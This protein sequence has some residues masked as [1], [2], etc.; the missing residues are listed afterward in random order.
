MLEKREILEDIRRKDFEGFKRSQSYYSRAG[1][2]VY[3]MTY[4]VNFQREV[5]ALAKKKGA[6]VKVWDVGCGQGRFLRELKQASGEKI[7]TVGTTATRPPVA[8]GID[9]L[10]IDSMAAPR[11]KSRFEKEKG[12]DLIVSL[13]SEVRDMKVK[14]IINRVLNRLGPE[15]KAFIDVHYPGKRIT[16]DDIAR[17]NRF[18]KGLEERLS[19]AG[20]G[21]RVLRPYTVV[22]DLSEP[23]KPE[24]RRE[25][26]A[27]F[28]C[29]EIKRK[30][31]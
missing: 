1:T 10:F 15:G 18:I 19:E 31:A 8:K 12:F 20:F 14:D 16:E 25:K 5:E 9:H 6:P 29:L 17:S 11:S 21:M 22:V 28:L 4:S 27:S 13:Q 30:K 3:N 2:A 24:Q 26:T 7:V 23:G